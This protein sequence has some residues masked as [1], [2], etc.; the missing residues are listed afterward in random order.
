MLTSVS[1]ND[2]RRKLYF[3]FTNLP[4]L[5]NY[6]VN[7]GEDDEQAGISKITDP[8]KT[9]SRASAKLKMRDEE[10]DITGQVGIVECAR[11]ES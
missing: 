5:F 9:F 6:A 1:A 8:Y 2:E 7:L 3:L 4:N 11:I 10:G